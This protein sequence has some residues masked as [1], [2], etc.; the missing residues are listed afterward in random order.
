M[1]DVTETLIDIE[2]EFIY[3]GTHLSPVLSKGF[4]NYFET[5]KDT[6]AINVQEVAGKGGKFYFNVKGKDERYKSY[7]P[8]AFV[9]MTSENIERF[10][11][12]LEAREKHEQ[13]KNLM[14]SEMQKVDTLGNRNEEGHYEK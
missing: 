12:Y 8:W 13:A 11:V 7:Y 3:I 5:P 14:I 6:I 2:G 9:K 4:G 1:F 10:N